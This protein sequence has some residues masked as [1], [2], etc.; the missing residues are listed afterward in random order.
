MEQ[1]IQREKKKRDSV[2][3]KK[4]GSIKIEE[5]ELKA[6]EEAAEYNVRL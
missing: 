3:G 4:K 1:V 5:K 6:S 2:A